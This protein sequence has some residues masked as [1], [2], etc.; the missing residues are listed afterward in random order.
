MLKRLINRIA[1]KELPP[2]K[3]SY[4]EAR[5]SL[6]RHAHN[7]RM[8]LAKRPDVEP[9]ILYYLATDEAVEVRRLVAANATTPL[10]ASKLLAVDADTEVRSALA[11][12]M[13][14]G[15]ATRG[16][17]LTVRER[18]LAS[19]IVELLAH[20]RDARVRAIVAEAFGSLQ[21]AHT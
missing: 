7:A 8:Y 14:S 20:D 3:M 4:E 1:D 10:Q 5:A 13:A 17:R 9:E 2:G 16:E 18:A 19:E 21:A 6:E 15:F 12:K 11:R